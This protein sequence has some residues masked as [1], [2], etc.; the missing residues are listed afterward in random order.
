MIRA[1]CACGVIAATLSI[2]PA[3]GGEGG[4]STGLAALTEKAGSG[5]ATVVLDGVREELETWPT[6]CGS[7][8]SENSFVMR[9]GSLDGDD[10]PKNNTLNLSVGGELKPRPLTSIQYKAPAEGATTEYVTLTG[11]AAVWI[12]N[13]RFVWSG[14]T[15]SGKR[16]EVDIECP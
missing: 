11:D 12:A 10:D 3:C 8:R 2:L 14:E 16:L 7:T 15:Q 4:S 1:M 13:N 9:G 5:K 6:M